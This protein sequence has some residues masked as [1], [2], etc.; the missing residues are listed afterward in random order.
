MQVQPYETTQLEEEWII[1]DTEHFHVTKLNQVGGFC[2]SRLQEEQTIES[3]VQALLES[4][5]LE[6]HV[7]MDS[8][9]QDVQTF[10]LQLESASLIKHVNR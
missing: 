6:R 5:D 2:W 10:I 3:L 9:Y 1:L 8:L 4:Y 7:D